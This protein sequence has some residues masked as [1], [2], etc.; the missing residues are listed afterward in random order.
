MLPAKLFWLYHSDTSGF[1]EGALYAPMHEPS[2]LAQWIADHDRLVESFTFR[3]YELL[4]VLA[5]VGTCFAAIK[6]RPTWIVPLLSLPFLLTFFHIFF[7]AKDRFHIPLDGIIAIMAATA[8]VELVRFLERG[9]ARYL[10]PLARG[11]ARLEPPPARA[12]PGGSRR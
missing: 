2:R 7:H 11:Q 3:Y 12:V 9:R 5:V 1:Y 6:W 8:V 4:M 10:G